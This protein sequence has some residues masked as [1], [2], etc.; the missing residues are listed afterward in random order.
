VIAGT[1][2]T[3]KKIGKQKYP[4]ITMLNKRVKVNQRGIRTSYELAHKK[5]KPSEFSHHIAQKI[6]VENT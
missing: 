1:Y 3:T 5:P 6:S 2:V 4:Y